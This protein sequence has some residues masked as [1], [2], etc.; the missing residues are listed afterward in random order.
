MR[1]LN[2][3]IALEPGNGMAWRQKARLLASMGASRPDLANAWTQAARSSGA[4]PWSADPVFRDLAA[5]LGVAQKTATK[6]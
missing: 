2:D 1:E 5:G 6:D 4:L 3:L